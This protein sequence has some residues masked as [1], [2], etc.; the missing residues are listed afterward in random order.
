VG[1]IVDLGERNEEALLLISEWSLL[2]SGQGLRRQV[3]FI[4]SKTQIFM[5]QIQMNPVTPRK[6]KLWRF[7]LGLIAI[8]V[9]TFALLYGLGIYKRWAGQNGVQQLAEAMDKAQKD[10]YAREMADTYGG[11]TPQETLA[12]YIAAVEKKDYVLASKYFTFSKQEVALKDLQGVKQEDFANFVSILRQGLNAK[13][14]YSDD[15]KEFV[16]H[17]PVIFDF[18]LYRSGLWKIAQI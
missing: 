15:K 9:L 16:I 3:L 10:E 13:G 4:L 17:K 14:S 12:M 6:S 11:K 7:F 5:D 1:F 2:A 18:F 8:V